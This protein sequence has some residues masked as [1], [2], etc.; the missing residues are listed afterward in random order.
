MHSGN[1][2]TSMLAVFKLLKTLISANMYGMHLHVVHRFLKWKVVAK[3]TKAQFSR[4]S[5]ALAHVY[6]TVCC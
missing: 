6:I 1:V 5:N 2:P 4:E 3:H